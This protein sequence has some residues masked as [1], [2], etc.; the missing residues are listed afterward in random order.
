MKTQAYLACGRLALALLAAT[1]LLMIPRGAA[2]VG[3]EP[4]TVEVTA[5]ANGNLGERITVQARLAASGAPVAKASIDFVIPTTFLNNQGEMVVAR[6]LTDAEGLATADFEARM[7]GALQVKAVFHGDDT[8][9]AA[10]SATAPL[11]V[12][13]SKQ[14]FVPDIGIRLRGVNS[15]P[16]GGQN[17]LG[18][19]FLSGWPIGAV[20][21]LVWSFYAVA[22]FFMS[23]ISADA[24]RTEEVQS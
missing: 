18:H 15:T 20:L 2:A 7:T 6:A 8:Y 23:R 21:L 24:D 19:W 3:Q 9:A 4:V 1:V 10:A 5:P 16:F 17:S 13:G 12:S 14:L 22:V 11:N